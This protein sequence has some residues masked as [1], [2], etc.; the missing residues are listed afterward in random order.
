MNREKNLFKNTI[1][2]FIGNFGSKFLGVIIL[3]LYTNF[4]NKDQFGY[5][6][7]VYTYI[8]LL[9]PFITLQLSDGIYRYLLDSKNKNEISNVI[10]NSLSIIGKNI[11]IANI[12]GLLLFQFVQFDYKYLF[13]IQL[14]SMIFYSIWIQI[15]R[16]LKENILYSLAGIYFTLVS[17]LLNVLTV[18]FFHYGVKGLIISNILASLLTFLYV[19]FKLKVFKKINAKLKNTEFKLK[20]I[21]FSLPLM[22]NV[23]SWWIMNVSDR[24]VLTYYMGMD[25]VGIYAIAN[26]FPSIILLLNT[27]FS[28][29]WQES[30]ITEHKSKDDADF[31]SRMFNHYLKF[32]FTGVIIFLAITKF[33]MALLVGKEFYSAWEYVPF[34]YLATIFSGFSSFYGASY[35]SSEKTLGSFYTSI[36]G[37]I[38]N[39]LLNII[40]IPHMGI[41]G[42]AISTFLSFLAMWVARIFNTRK[43]FKAKINIQ[44]LLVLSVIT[45]IFIYLY[46]YNNIFLEIALIFVAFVVFA[47]YNKN[48]LIQGKSLVFRKIKGN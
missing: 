3:P 40:L 26:R 32:Q 44:D 30:V 18:M 24:S 6:D 38:L 4:L 36:I 28:L 2:Y 20:L 33:L 9:T 35:L 5:Y 41:Q 19:E 31:Y 46:F 39:L 48:L 10:T 1:I 17:L 22:P 8:T 21:K 15:A 43:F 14:N 12:I 47:L 45:G 27:I 37:A 16:G 11:I 42:A 7:L 25:S 23:V 34:L 13:L 29:A